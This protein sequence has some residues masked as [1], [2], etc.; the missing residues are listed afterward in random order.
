MSPWATTALIVWGVISLPVGIATGKA[1]KRAGAT[2]PPAPVDALTEVRIR[3]WQADQRRERP[4][5]GFKVADA[6]RELD[7]ELR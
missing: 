5:P 3:A 7:R 1:L 4:R 6:L 2:Y